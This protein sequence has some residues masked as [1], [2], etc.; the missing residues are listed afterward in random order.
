MCT[1]SSQTN[2]N[3]KQRQHNKDWNH[4]IVTGIVH[5][6]Q[7]YGSLKCVQKYTI[8]PSGKTG[9]NQT[10]AQCKMESYFVP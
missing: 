2:I 3:K 4:K 10:Q 9:L 6:I 5:V 1:T 7:V 8:K